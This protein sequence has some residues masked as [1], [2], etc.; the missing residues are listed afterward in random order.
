MRRLILAFTLGGLFVAASAQTPP[1]TIPGQSAPLRAYIPHSI[2]PE[3]QAIYEKYQP[4]LLAPAQEP[5]TTADEFEKMYRDN[6]AKSLPRSEAIVKQLGSLVTEEKLGGVSAIEVRPKGYKDDGSVLI[7]VHGG[8]FILGS[9]KSSLADAATTAQ[10]TG[11]RVISVDYTVAPKGTWRTVTDQVVAVYKAVLASGTMAGRIGLY[12]GSA[13]GEIVA[14]STLKLRDEGLPMPAALILLSPAVDLTD[15]GDT[16][17]TLATADPVLN[18]AWVMPVMYSY[19]PDA[20]ARKTAYASPIYGDF[21]KGYPPTLIQGGTKE[22]LLSDFVRLYQA[23]KTHGGT[24]ELDLYEGMPHG[25]Q[26]IFASAPE[27]KA[28][29]AE[30]R[31]FW[32]KYLPAE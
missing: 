3:A 9:A 5:A 23:I 18:P 13:G 8:G 1:A 2:S 15:T 21:S 29:A 6:E 30:Q 24:V 25:F 31:K 26:A 22:W 32:S 28:A 12:G 10:M 17:V 4:L 27:G 14:A 19:C 7:Y 11:K 16:R 20:V